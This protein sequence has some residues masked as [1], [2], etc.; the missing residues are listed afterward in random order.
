MK[1]RGRI[2]ELEVVVMIDSGGSQ[3]FIN[4]TAIDRLG[5]HVTSIGKFR[6]RLEDGSLSNSRE[7]CCDV[8]VRLGSTQI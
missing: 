7:V 5:L 2:A 6:V 4:Q 8:K 1:L 3:C